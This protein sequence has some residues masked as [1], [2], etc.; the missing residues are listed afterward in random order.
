[1]THFTEG[2]NHFVASTVAPVASGWSNCRVGLSPTGKAPP[3]H[4]ARQ[5]QTLNE[6]DLRESGVQNIAE[7]V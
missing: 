2:F 3:Y 4:G 5:F 7:E 1:V 6:Y